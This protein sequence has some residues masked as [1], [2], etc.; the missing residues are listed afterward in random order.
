M[1]RIRPHLG[2][3]V[4]AVIAV[5]FCA[6]GLFEVLVRPLAEDVVEGPVALNVAAVLLGTLPLAVRRRAPLGVSL[7]MYGVLAG[8]ALAADPLELYAT[9]LALLVATYTVASYAPLRD[10][11]LSAAVSVLAVAVAVV[12]GS[13]TDAAPDPLASLVLFGTVWL[14]GRVVGVRN[15]RATALLHARDAHAAEAVAA[16]RARIARE[17][18]DVVS[19]SLAAIVMQSGGAR[20]VLDSDPERAKDSLAAIERSARQGL[21]EMRRLLGLLG[22][23]AEGE[24]GPQPGLARLDDLVGDVRAAGLRVDCRVDGEP[25]DLPPAVDVSAY[26]VLQEALTNVMKHARAHTVQVDVRYLP[27]GLELEVTDDG[28]GGEPASPDGGRGLVGMRERVRVLGGSVVAGPR[29]SA[30]GFRVL[31]RLPA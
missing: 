5:A 29:G 20:N 18:H 30:P 2:Q 15:E 4:D 28:P 3:L 21:E 27:D 26:R 8:R 23:E 11:L 14:V 1:N 6:V 19:H 31:A 9:Y 12:Q 16:E 22:D 25:R 10:A 24:R 7:L 17:M 13:G